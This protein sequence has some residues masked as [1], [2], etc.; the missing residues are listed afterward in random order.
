MST[1]EKPLVAINAL[2]ASGSHSYRSAGI[3]AYIVHLLRHLPREAVSLRLTAIA[4][5]GKLLDLPIARQHTNWP[6]ER[7]LVRI[8]YEQLRLPRLLRRMGASLLHATAFV[9]PFLSAVPQVITVHDLSFLRYPRFFRTSRRLYLGRLTG[10][11]CRRARAV[12]AVSRFTAREVVALLGVPE[13]R[14]HVIYHGV[15]PRFRPLPA[16]VVEAFRR[17]KG[18]PQRYILHLGTLEPRKNLPT[19]IRAF[20]RLRD[21][22]LHLVLAGGRGWL[23]NPIFELVASLG[24]EGR[25]HFPGY[26]PDEELP[27]WYNA[28]SLFASLSHY[29]GFGMPVVEAEACGVPV[30]AGN[31]ASLPEAAGDGAL[32]VPPTD[33]EAVREAMARLLTD[34]ALRER[35][36][37]AGL[38]HS[39][40]F[41]WERTARETLA[42][43]RAVLGMAS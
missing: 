9:G 10:P 17:R 2:L 37:Q 42:L 3:H 7:P 38:A 14:V 15:D 28:A 24:L 4:G 43:Y 33:E 26:V 6:T 18:L 41:T 22:T 32:L 25:V 11:A 16:E 23:D 30:V 35:V 34:A 1:K 12:I 39:R 5:P 36:R 21:P 31:R 19:L 20:A 40:T 8:A 27:L 29:E 13:E